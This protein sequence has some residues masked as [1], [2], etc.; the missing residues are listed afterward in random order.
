M[1]TYTNQ[2]NLA[3]NFLR[4]YGEDMF[5][6]GASITIYGGAQPTASTVAT[7]WSS[8]RSSNVDCL[9]HFVTGPSWAYNAGTLTWYNTNNTGTTNVYNTGTAT[10]AILWTGE[11]GS[12]TT[13]TVT[14]VQVSGSTLPNSGA[15]FVVPVSGSTG[16]GVIRMVDVNVVPGTT[17]TVTSSGMAFVFG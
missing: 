1:P 17:A 10:W 15:F 11:T 14:T 9:A 16:T 12:A 4:A 2:Q 8:Y 5:T 3:N 6:S 13:G 7:S